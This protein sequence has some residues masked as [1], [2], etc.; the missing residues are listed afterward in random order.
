MVLEF[1]LEDLFKFSNH[2]VV[3]GTIKPDLLPLIY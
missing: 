3:E 2:M 1:F